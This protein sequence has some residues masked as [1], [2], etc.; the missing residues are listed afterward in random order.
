RQ[1]VI[2]YDTGSLKSKLRRADKVGS[3][4]VFILGPDELK[5]GQ[6]ILKDMRKGGQETVPFKDMVNLAEVLAATFLKE[7][8]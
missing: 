2:D 1:V 8:Q 7:G 5:S 4:Q 3:T 6:G